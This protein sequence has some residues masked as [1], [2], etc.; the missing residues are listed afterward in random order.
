MD[1]NELKRIL[2]RAYSDKILTISDNEGFGEMG[3]VFNL[4]IQEERVRFEINTEAA[5]RSE[6]KISSKVLSIAKRIKNIK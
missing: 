2:G 4:F 1:E 5:A 6:V 3:V